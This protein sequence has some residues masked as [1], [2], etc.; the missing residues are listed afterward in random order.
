[1]RFNTFFVISTINSVHS[2]FTSD[3]RFK[4]TIETIQSIR[5][6][7]PGSNILLT[8]NSTKP[9]T[10]SQRIL[11]K[12]LT[13]NLLECENTLFTDY[14]N[15]TGKNKGLNELLAY[16]QLI[17]FANKNGLLGSR[18]FKLSGR[19]SLSP[20]F[21]QWEWQ[22]PKY[23]GKY[24]FCITPWVYNEGAGEFLKYFY[25]TALWSMCYTLVPEYSILMQT[26]FN[27]MM[28]TDDNLEMAHNV[29]IPKDKL[30]VVSNVGGHGWITNGEWTE[31]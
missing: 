29:H 4:Q 3:D 30:V 23:H 17:T 8:D 31:F 25:N 20:R 28:Q 1:M 5:Q 2:S 26:M 15:K 6:H 10:T 19:Y 21:D 13:D 27:W 22:K 14:I 7:S 24:G 12:S 18:I 11:L 9:L 16:Q